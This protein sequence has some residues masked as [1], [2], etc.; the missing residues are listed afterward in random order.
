[1]DRTVRPMAEAELKRAARTLLPS[2]AFH[3]L[4]E[5]R[6][7]LYWWNARRIRPGRTRRIAQRIVAAGKPIKLEIGSGPRTGFEEW[8]SL[9]LAAAATL[10]H[11]LT[12]PLPFPDESVD[13]IYSSH[14]LEH[15]TYPT[16]LLP[17]LRECRRVLRTGGRFRA[18]VPNAR[19]YLE[20]YFKPEGF[21]RA[22]FCGFDVGLDYRSRIDVVNFVAYLGGEHKF[23]FDEENL[24]RVIEEAGFRNVRAREFD[25]SIDVPERVYD[26]IY[27]DAV[28]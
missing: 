12:K 23:L 27:V 20:A 1:M 9:D 19:R 14:V 11:D 6:R 5:L 21:D 15:F 22:T 17:L 4:V 25:P 10:Q 3:W 26:S 18:A 16:E 7:R 13:E 24:P 8:I 28:K 2:R